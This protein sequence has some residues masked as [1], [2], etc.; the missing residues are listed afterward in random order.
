[1]YYSMA[2]HSNNIMINGNVRYCCVNINRYVI[3]RVSSIR[4]GNIT[5][6]CIPVTFVRVTVFKSDEISHVFYTALL[7]SLLRKYCVTNQKV[8]GSIP[9]GAIG[10]F[11]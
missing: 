8:V 10:I 11:H 5:P 3:I 2:S 4:I 7:S 9:D 1:M 6:K